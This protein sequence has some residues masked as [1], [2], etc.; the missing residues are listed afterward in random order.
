VSTWAIRAVEFA[1]A[2]RGWRCEV[3]F[4][5]QTQRQCTMEDH[6]VYDGA[7]GHGPL[8]I[9][10]AY[11]RGLRAMRREARRLRAIPGPWTLDG[12]PAP[13]PARGETP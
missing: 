8:S 10:L 13:A 2:T 9:L 1:R 5:V 12:K 7:A 3:A 6:A 11:L 4:R